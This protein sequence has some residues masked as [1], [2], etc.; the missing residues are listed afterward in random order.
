MRDFFETTRARVLSLYREGK[1]LTEAQGSV[2]ISDLRTRFV[3]RRGVPYSAE[4]WK[5]WS[6]RLIERMVQGVHGFARL[7]GQPSPVRAR[8]AFWAASC[9]AS[10]LE[11][12]SPSDTTRPATTHCTRKRGRW[13]GPFS[14]ATT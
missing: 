3:N 5:E 13:L 8:K 4:D 12:P 11:N 9:W 6:G 2:D 7:S 14:A 1:N 10:F